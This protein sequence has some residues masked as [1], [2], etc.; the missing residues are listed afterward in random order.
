[1]AH[2]ADVPLVTAAYLVLCAALLAGFVLDAPTVLPLALP[3]AVPVAWLAVARRD[4]RLAALTLVALAGVGAAADARRRDAACRERAA[5]L[6]SWH[7]VLSDVARPGG[8]ARGSAR[9]LGCPLRVTLVVRAGAADAGAVVLAH[10]EASVG[11][12]GAL[13]RQAV[14][15]PTGARDLLPRLRASAGA[16]IDRQ[17]GTR[18]PLVRA[19][20]VADARGIDPEVREAFAAAGWCT[21]SRSRGCTWRSSRRRSSSCCARRACRRARRR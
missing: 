3:L 7:V 19:L 4:V 8:A 20:V 10:G 14:I 17:F 18:A 12:A 5:R 13:I 2:A 11:E 1:V 16:S 15:V 6:R 21:R 9:A